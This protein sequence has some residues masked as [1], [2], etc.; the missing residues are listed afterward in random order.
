MTT[1]QDLNAQKLH[2]Q[3]QLAA[4]EQQLSDLQSAHR[5]DAIAKVK[6]MLAEHGLTVA[7]LGAASARSAAE[8]PA[9]ALSKVAAK[10][11]DSASGNTWS[12]RGLKPR[13]LT[14]ALAAGKTV[15][16]FAI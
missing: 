9:K 4:I 16:D 15:Q 3:Q 1:I 13:W 11:R 8:K 10:Y 14:A 12:G 6:A 5:Q 2:L 7:D